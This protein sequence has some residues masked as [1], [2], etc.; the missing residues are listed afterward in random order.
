M[1]VDPI[2]PV[3]AEEVPAWH[4]HA[5]V[6][7]VGSGI[8][9]TCAA[10]EA[11][12]AGAE[13]LVVER[14]GAAGGT[15]AA[16]GGILYLGGGTATQR[17]CGFEDSPEA[18]AT[19][20][21]AACG[22]GADEAKVRA[23]CEGSVAHHDWLVAHG[24]PFEPAFCDEPNREP[25]GIEGL[26][27]SGGED[28][29]PFVDLTPPV[30]RGHCPAYPD[31]AGVFLMEHLAAAR[32]HAGAH[33]VV[34]SRV[35]RLV[36]D[37]TGAV[38][39]VAAREAG[40]WR[41]L[42][43]RR[44]VVLAGG[45]FIANDEMLRHWCPE[46]LRADPLWRIGTDADDGRVIRMA[47]GAGAAAERMDAFECSLPIGPPHRMARGV[48]VNGSGERFINEDTYTGRI[49]LAA[50]VD[51]EGEVFMIV[52]ESVFEVNLVGMRYS[53]VAGT[54]EELAAEIDLPPET[55]AATLEEYNADATA[56]VDRRFHKLAPWLVPLQPP[57]G[58]VDLRAGSGTIYAT[59]T[60]GGIATDPDSRVLGDDG[61][62]VTGLW[63]AGRCTAGLAAGG[64]AS[65]ISL[66]DASFFGRRAGLFAA[67]PAAG[68]RSRSGCQASAPC[69]G[70]STTHLGQGQATTPR[71]R[72]AD[73]ERRVTERGGYP[74]AARSSSDSPPQ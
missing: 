37:A 9:G 60:L 48:L 36:V 42:G 22:P 23:Y 33:L 67:Q 27:F 16:S 4:R 28:T 25:E 1:T 65:G 54:A 31:T 11:A 10:I 18:M 35:E 74:A 24:V 58:A 55:L 63:A 72:A 69:R 59:F 20:L 39:G 52:D 46:V 41:Y 15:S 34:D 38:V 6:V 29:W 51:Q 53:W 2:P 17:A 13:V 73:T 19:F 49:G 7:V 44:G 62:P 12:E 3:P 30:P 66:G 40:T 64:Y 68:Q 26:Q 70:Q 61:R 21:M 57:Y 8:A 56:G 47:Q 32:D 50:L 71:S 45:G 14:A 5:D 43:A